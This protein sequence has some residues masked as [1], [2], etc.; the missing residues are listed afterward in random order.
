LESF[1]NKPGAKLEKEMRE[2]GYL[3]VLANSAM[4]G[5]VKVGKTT[6]SSS[7][8]AKELSGATGLPTPF[9]V[10]Y[11]QIFEDCGSAESF[12]HAYLAQQ[13]Y[14]VSDNRE[15]FSAPVNI[16]V[17]AIIL[18]SGAIDHDSFQSTPEQADDLL[19]RGE[20]DELESL[21]L[22][23]SDLTYPWSSV[24]AEAEARLDGSDDF[25]IEN[26]AEA[27]RLFCQAARLGALPAYGRIGHMY[28]YG[29]D[30]VPQNS[31]KSLE[32]FKEGARKG[33][34]YCYWAMGMLF[35]RAREGEDWQNAEKC[36]RLF[37]RHMPALPDG[38]H[39][40]K[41]ELDFI[42]QDC[43]YLLQ[44]KVNVTEPPAALS[45]FFVEKASQIRALL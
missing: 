31:I 41:L 18:A 22:S 42:F 21:S 20:P 35:I 7:E 13:G 8:R 33:S 34:A 23:Q 30:G 9:I 11:E 38:Q 1:R 40:T 29:A 32:F 16:V 39:L 28:Q 44:N 2:L 12:V 36:F 37:L 10:V 27:L 15:F 45:G 24:F 3:Y 4:P 14:R 43:V 5:L 17:R 19:E 26:H 6:R 25:I